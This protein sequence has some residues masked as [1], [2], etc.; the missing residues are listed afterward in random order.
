MTGLAISF[1]LALVALGALWW[2]REGVSA[3]RPASLFIT[4]GVGFCTSPWWLP[5]VLS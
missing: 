4:F 2:R 3:E 5:W 1:G